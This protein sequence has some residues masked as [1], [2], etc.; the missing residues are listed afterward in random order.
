MQIQ[1]PDPLYAEAKRIARE[2]QISLAE[3]MRRGL[4]YMSRVYPPLHSTQEWA[5]PKPKHLGSFN[6]SP[7]KW[8]EL[9]NKTGK[10]PKNKSESLGFV[11]RK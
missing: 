10:S 2:R 11:R 7:D 1:L 8:R 3:V 5:P 9:A 6:V 4:E